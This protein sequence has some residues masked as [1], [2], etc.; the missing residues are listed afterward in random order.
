VIASPLA[1]SIARDGN[2]DL[3]GV[4]GTGPGGRIIAADVKGT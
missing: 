1:K 3:R 2:I 4:A